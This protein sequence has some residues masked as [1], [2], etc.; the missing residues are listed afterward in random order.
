MQI[1]D[2]SNSSYED[3]GGAPCLSFAINFSESH[4]YH[5]KTIFKNHYYISQMRSLD[6]VVKGLIFV[7]Q[8]CSSYA[9]L[10]ASTK[11]YQKYIVC[12]YEMHQYKIY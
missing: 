11:N 2:Y 1:N 6:V 7:L 9:S 3:T 5:N 8:H 12:S 10:Q 4:L